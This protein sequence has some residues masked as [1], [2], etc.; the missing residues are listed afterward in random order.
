MSTQPNEL[1]TTDDVAKLLKLTDRQVRRM[2]ADGSG[3]P[4]IRL[5]ERTYRYSPTVVADWTVEQSQT[6]LDEAV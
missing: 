2:R 6:R 1:L 3:P 5:G 4:F